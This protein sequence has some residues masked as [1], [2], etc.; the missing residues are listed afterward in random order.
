[1]E[2]ASSDDVDL[3]EV[4]DRFQRGID[5][6]LGFFFR[7]NEVPPQSSPSHLVKT[8]LNVKSVGVG[9]ALVEDPLLPGEFG[10]YSRT[11]TIHESPS[12]MADLVDRTLGSV[13]SWLACGTGD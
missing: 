12:L 1:M 2:A 6:Q 4:L 10:L 9:V 11:S 8:D 5:E 3:V 13:S 7:G